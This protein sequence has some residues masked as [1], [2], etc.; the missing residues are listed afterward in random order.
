MID[1]IRTATKKQLR[2]RAWLEDAITRLGLGMRPSEFPP[3]MHAFFG[4]LNI[5]QYPI[6]LAPYLIE[7]SGKGITSYAEIGLFQGGTFILTVE[8]LSRFNKLRT[9]LGIDVR[10]TESVRAYADENPIVRLVESESSL[11]PAK[12]ALAKAK[13]DLVFIDA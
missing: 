7:L 5:W 2:S 8:Y 1:I 3:E 13:P 11:D 10:L 12:Q 4:G 9:A 6:Q